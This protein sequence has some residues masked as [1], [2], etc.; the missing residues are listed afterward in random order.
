MH[1]DLVDYLRNSDG[2]KAAV[3]SHNDRAEI[4]WGVRPDAAV[5]PSVT[6]THVS[7]TP[8][9]DQDGRSE[10]EPSRIQ[11]DV[12]SNTFFEGVTIMSLIRPLLEVPSTFGNTKFDR[13]FLESGPRSLK[14][15]DLDGGER[16]FHYS[17]DFII[18][19]KPI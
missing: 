12:W 11:V 7:T 8:M 9:Y 13:G 3:A 2:L 14:T 18:W 6:L 4:D 10:L 19:H 15:Q 1:K 17:A 5:N 16:V